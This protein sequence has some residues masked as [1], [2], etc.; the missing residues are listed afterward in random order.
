VVAA[1][2][3]AID[4]LIEE[5]GISARNQRYHRN[6]Q[7]LRDRLERLGFHAYISEENQSPIITSFLYPKENFEFENFYTFVKERGYVIYPGK[8][9]DADTFRIGNIGEIYEEDIQEL[10]DIIENYLGVTV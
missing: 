1:F 4:E 2:S 10:C 5:G 9:T 8:L 6:N 3:K 7:I